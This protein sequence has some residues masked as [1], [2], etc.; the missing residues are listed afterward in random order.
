MV[1]PTNTEG[2][3]DLYRSSKIKKVDLPMTGPNKGPLQV[4]YVSEC[5]QNEAIVTYV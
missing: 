2:L 5:Y 1:G 4:C 3:N